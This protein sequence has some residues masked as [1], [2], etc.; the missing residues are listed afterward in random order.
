MKKS[1]WF[2][3]A[4]LSLVGRSD[5]Q[6]DPV[7]GVQRRTFPITIFDCRLRGYVY[8]SRRYVCEE[9]FQAANSSEYLLGVVHPSMGYLS[10]NTLILST[11]LENNLAKR[12]GHPY[13]S[14][15]SE[16]DELFSQAAL[17]KIPS[18]TKI[19]L[20]AFA[21][22]YRFEIE[23]PSPPSLKDINGVLL[24]ASEELGSSVTVHVLTIE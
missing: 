23:F 4:V 21:N 1:L 13:L 8:A 15:G 3:M 2:L 22:G 16:A 9:T 12:S 10:T 19:Y 11:G 18:G 20:I 17:V 24:A 6:A 5:V 14:L 7:A